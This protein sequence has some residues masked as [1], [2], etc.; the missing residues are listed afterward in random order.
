MAKKQIIE[1]LFERCKLRNSFEF[2]NSLV[3]SIVREYGLNT[4]PYDMTKIDDL[5]KLPENVVK[6]DY[7]IAHLGSGKHKFIKGINNIYHA[8]EKIEN[9]EYIEWQYKPSILNDFSASESSILSLANNQGILQDFLYRDY[10]CYNAPKM[11]NSERKRNISFEYYIGKEKFESNKLQIE[12]DLTLEN[13]GYVTVFEGK[14]ARP[15]KWL[16]NFNLYQ[17]Y[18]PFRY[19]C[20]LKQKN[21][22]NIGKLTACYLIRQRNKDGSRV[23]LYNY[24]FENPV[25]I[26]SIKLIKKREYF[27]KKKESG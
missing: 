7:F 27:L 22:L 14:N 10:S 1:A 26:T 4:N 5:S 3:K 17:L 19:Y 23:R 20:D 25:D 8:F 11:Y 13:K 16:E 6:E 2:D 9:S 24:I 21:K 18:N 12:I 15:N